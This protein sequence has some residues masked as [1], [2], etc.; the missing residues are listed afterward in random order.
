MFTIRSR[1]TGIA[2]I[3]G[4]SFI[5]PLEPLLDQSGRSGWAIY[6]AGIRPEAEGWSGRSNEPF[7][8]EKIARHVVEAIEAMGDFAE[9]EFS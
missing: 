4:R 2:K 3:S 5:I 8:S 9:I 1:S 7:D 6:A